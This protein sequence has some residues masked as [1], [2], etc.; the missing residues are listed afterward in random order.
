MDI[1]SLQESI[2]YNPETGVLVWRHRPVNSAHDK[3]FNTQ[4]S[5]NE[6]GT[7]SRLGYRVLSHKGKVFLGHRVAWAVHYGEIPNGEID[8]I[9]GNRKDNRISNLR[10]VSKKENTRNKG[11]L[12]NNTSGFTGV[13]KN[14]LTG[15]WISY[16]K[17]NGKQIKIGSYAKLEDAVKAR[18]KAQIKFGFHKN[19][20]EYREHF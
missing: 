9:N 5:G 11:K 7:I 15:K 20:G 4:F 13:S 12:R 10:D 8:H 6:V 18:E 17:V 2:L 14:A 1:A 3:T 16:I 19:H